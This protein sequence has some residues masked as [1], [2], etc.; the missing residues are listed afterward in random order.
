VRGVP[1][2]PWEG[3][4]SSSRWIRY[5]SGSGRS[6]SARG[7]EQRPIPTTQPAPRSAERVSDCPQADQGDSDHHQR[8][9][10]HVVAVGSTAATQAGQGTVAAVVTTAATVLSLVLVV[11]EG[12]GN[13]RGGAVLKA[14]DDPAGQRV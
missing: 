1:P 5:W 7:Q 2:C 10:G 4:G 12:Q 11:L 8:A 3:G 6:R 14:Q 9:D 13:R